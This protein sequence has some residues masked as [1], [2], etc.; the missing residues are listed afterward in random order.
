MQAGTLLREAWKRAGLSQSELA[1]R[2]VAPESVISE[3]RAGKRQ[4]AVPTLARLVAAP[5]HEFTLGL[6]RT[7]GYP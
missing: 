7:D 2:A 6:E 5:G 1:R 4:P 3:F